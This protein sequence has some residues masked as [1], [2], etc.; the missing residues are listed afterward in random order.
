VGDVVDGAFR[1]VERSA[2]AIVSERELDVLVYCS[3]TPQPP[4]VVSESDSEVRLTV[5]NAAP[6]HECFT[7]LNVTLEAALG[8]RAIV[9]G[10]DSTTVAVHLDFR[11]GD[12]VT[13]YGRCDDI[14][15]P[16]PREI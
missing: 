9:D 7:P 11:C 12:P 2:D 6:Q 5:T 15:T 3:D 16:R 14:Y 10:H 4:M 13:P 1:G 8:T